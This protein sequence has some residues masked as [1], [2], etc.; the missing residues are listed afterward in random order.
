MLLDNDNKTKG[1][2]SAL[3]KARHHLKSY[4]RKI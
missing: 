3:S 1:L 2:H 4:P